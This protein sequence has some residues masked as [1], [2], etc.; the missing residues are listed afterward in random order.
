MATLFANTKG[1]KPY[2]IQIVFESGLRLSQRMATMEAADE[3][4]HHWAQ[5][6]KGTQVDIFR[7]GKHVASRFIVPATKEEIV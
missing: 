5:E 1:K 7:H 4:A 6:H 3:I 2:L